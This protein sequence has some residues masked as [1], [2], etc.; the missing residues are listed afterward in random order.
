[1]QEP[2]RLDRQPLDRMTWRRVA[3]TGVVLFVA[4]A[5][6]LFQTSNPNLYPTVILIGSFLVPVSFVA[7]LSDHQDLT[8]LTFEALVRAFVLG[9]L[10]G[11]LGASVLEPFLLP[12]FISSG[13]QLDPGGGILVGLIEEGV[14]LEAVVLIAR[15]MRHTGALDG[16]LLGAAVGMGFA[17]LESTGYAFTTLLATNGDVGAS[18]VET[19]VRAILAPFGHGV[20][21]A[22]V[23]AVLFRESAIDRFR[24]TPRLVLAFGFVVVLHGMWDGLPS[25]FAVALPFGVELSGSMI[26]ISVLG[27]VALGLSFRNANRQQRAL[28]QRGLL[29]PPAEG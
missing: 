28:E 20:W 9:G 15:R 19:V 5:W 26:A 11:V 1:M 13:Q 16:L 29:P 21:T 7:F 12:R 14:K 2:T 3:G 22:I 8:T 6:L 24:A 23:G 10:L 4:T 18:L 25:R 27:L 17:A